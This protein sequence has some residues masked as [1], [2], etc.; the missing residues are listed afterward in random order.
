MR[1]WIADDHPIFRDGLRDIVA[2]VFDGAEIADAGDMDALYALAD[3]QPA[4]DLLILDIVFPGLD[5]PQDLAKVRARLPTS[6]IVAVSMVSA[7]ADISAIMAAGA[8]GFIA[9]STRPEIMS[10]ALRALMDGEAVVLSPDEDAPAI[11]AETTPFGGDSALLN[12]LSPR[13]KDVLRLLA[14]GRSNKEIARELSL[15]PFT[16]RVHVSALLRG[17]G[18]TGR[19]AAAAFAAA[20]GFR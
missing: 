18:V 8:N 17:L 19:A 5:E 12:S 6:V 4:P 7:H 9:K 3:S 14:Q 13:Q 15:S 16:V 20:H 10:D 11:P 1:I 2:K